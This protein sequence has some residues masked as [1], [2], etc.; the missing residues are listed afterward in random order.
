MSNPIR[1]IVQYFDAEVPIV[2][3]RTKE[4]QNR[5]SSALVVVE[6][7]RVDPRAQFNIPPSGWKKVLDCRGR[8]ICGGLLL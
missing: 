3:M 1:L 4:W 6:Y 8:L 7:D 5:L 2:A